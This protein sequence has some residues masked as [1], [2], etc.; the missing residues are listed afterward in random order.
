M[1][2]HV[3]LVSH[4]GCK[5]V[6]LLIQDISAYFSLVS[7]IWMLLFV[8]V[9]QRRRISNAHQMGT[10]LSHVSHFLA[11]MILLNDSGLGRILLLIFGYGLQLAIISFPH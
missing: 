7:E 8:L 9:E 5:M 1:K 10:S 11:A 3:D 4:E 2:I 6:N